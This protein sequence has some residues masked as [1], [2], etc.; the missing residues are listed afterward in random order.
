MMSF[1][2]SRQ[3]FL[4]FGLPLYMIR[5]IFDSKK[6]PVHLVSFIKHDGLFVSYIVLIFFPFI[7]HDGLFVPYIVHI[8]L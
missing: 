6:C 5:K 4:I 8:F 1:F 3:S 7:K 2:R